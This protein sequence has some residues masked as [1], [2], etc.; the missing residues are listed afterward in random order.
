MPFRSS[1]STSIVTVLS[2]P[3]LNLPT[4]RRLIFTT[5]KGADA[6][7]QASRIGRATR[8]QDRCFEQSLS[9][10]NV[11]ESPASIEQ[12]SAAGYLGLQIQLILNLCMGV[13]EAGAYQR[14]CYGLR[15]SFEI[16]WFRLEKILTSAATAA[17]ATSGRGE[18]W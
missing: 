8:S 10:A 15:K 14:S 6:V 1:T 17:A 3:R 5:K 12:N 7:S 4:E 9:V 16:G 11:P 2:H 18:R 13:D